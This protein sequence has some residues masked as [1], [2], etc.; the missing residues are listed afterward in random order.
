MQRE[1][2]GKYSGLPDFWTE[3]IKIRAD[4]FF[5]HLKG[6]KGSVAIIFNELYEMY[7]FNFCHNLAQ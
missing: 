7:V 6:G 5:V 3:S 2:T 4:A 1:H